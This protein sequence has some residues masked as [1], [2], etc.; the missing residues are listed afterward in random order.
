MNPRQISKFILFTIILVT[1]GLGYHLQY[2]QFSYDVEDFFPIDNE[3]TQFF[4][5]FRQDFGNDDDYVLIGIQNKKGIFQQAFL[6]QIDSLSKRIADLP[7]IKKVQSI[8]NTNEFRRSSFYHKLMEVPYLHVSEPEKY[9]ADSSRI[10]NAPLLVNYLVSSDAKS[11]LIYIENSYLLDE[12]GCRILTED[13]QRTLKGFHFDQTHIAGRCT[14]QTVYVAMIQQEVRTFISISIVV[15]ILVLWLTYRSFW[16]LILPLSVVGLTVLWTMSIMVIVGKPIDLVSN[17]I[18]TILMIIG[19]ADVIHLL[20]HYLHL[21]AENQN[22]A[23]P[24]SSAKILNKAIKEVGMATLLTTFTTAI[25]FLTLTTSTF[26]PLVNLGW[27]STIGLMI[28]LCLTYTLVPAILTLIEGK[29]HIEAQ[30]SKSGINAFLQKNNLNLERLFNWTIQR[31]RTIVVITS[32]ITLACIFGASQ[33]KV[34]NYILEDLKEDHL[35]RK[36]FAFFAEEFG[37]ARAFELVIHT[38]DSTQ[39]VLD[40]EVL[41]EIEKIE[42]F[43]T[44]QYGVKNLVSPV[45]LMKSFNQIYNQGLSEQY[46]LPKNAKKTREFAKRLQ[47]N[48]DKIETNRLVNSQQN[49]GRISGKTPD[50][51]SYIMRQKNADLHDFIAKELGESQ[52]NYRITGTAHLMDLNNSFLAENVLM[53]LAIAIGIIAILFAFLLPSVKLLWLVLIPNILPLLFIAGMMGFVGIDLKVSTSIIF[54]IAFGIAV[55]DSIHFLSRFR[56]EVRQHTVLEA[57]RRTYLTTGKAIVVTSL[58]LA[59]GFLTLCSSNFLGTFHM[60]LLVAITLLVALLADLLL[61][62]V[63]LIRFYKPKRMDK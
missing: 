4:E 45:V 21:K 7:N 46:R 62:P 55:D 26:K 35:Q 5:Q 52:L 48:A 29:F 44:K 31:G 6:E 59:A 34:N 38:K 8:T 17:V 18:P 41:K 36:D 25:G 32:M 19:I 43:L 11:L 3:H 60:G 10:Y 37:G 40:I 42:D 30:K 16:G 47:Q 1:I 23:S 27:Y 14:G 28:A 22:Q 63:L 57:V 54:I 49:V 15:I 13:L 51:G 39:T 9:P 12:N 61:L 56:R 20:T 33:I 53:G 2:L 58:I 24:I 50:W